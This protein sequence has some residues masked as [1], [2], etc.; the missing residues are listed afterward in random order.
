MKRILDAKYEKANLNKLVRDTI[1][2]DR[3]EQ[4]KLLKLL[5]KYESVFDG[6]LDRPT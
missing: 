2:L 3:D 5:K 1:Y 6:T 4:D